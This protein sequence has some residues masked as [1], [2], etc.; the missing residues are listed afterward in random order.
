MLPLNGVVP[1]NKQESDRTRQCWENRD[2]P[3]MK[4]SGW[5]GGNISLEYMPW[6]ESQ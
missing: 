3:V 4:V 5:T 2:S 6:M 1:L